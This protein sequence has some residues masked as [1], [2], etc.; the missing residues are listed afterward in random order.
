MSETV[1]LAHVSDVH[2]SPAPGVALRHLNI[3]RGLGYLNW[4]RQRR[5][6]HNRAA[7]DLV[8]A[9]ML[10]HK[11]DHIAVTGDL[12][13]LGLP[14]EYEAATA[15]LQEVGAPADVTVVPGNHDIYSTLRDDP[16]VAR[17]ADYMRADAW[18]GK[19]AASPPAQF[20]FVRRIGP[21][22]LIGLNSAVE[23]PPFVAAGEVGETQLAAIDALLPR[24]EAE[25]LVRVVL[26]HHPPLPGQAPPRRALRDAA[27]L[28]AIL[29][30]RGAELVLHGH[31]HRDSHMD[32]AR[33]AE[34]AGG[35]IPVIGVASG[36]IARVHK[37]EP[38]GRYNL[39]RI[40]R[41]GARAE[42]EC[43]T[44][45]L[46]VGANAVTQIERKFVA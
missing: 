14:A 15:W 5:H 19:F 7:L 18:G 41:V 3:K 21:V 44:R 9:D 30:R 6:T 25:G 2:L 23:T 22:A 46:D 1:T 11:P 39:L 12:I 13:N 24:L 32:F 33:I 45:G 36:S 29:A 28:S 8:V 35:S 20:P 37:G 16:G 34:T 27:A 17:W 38:L 31:N 26:I 42:I 4:Q 40:T 43:V 10:R